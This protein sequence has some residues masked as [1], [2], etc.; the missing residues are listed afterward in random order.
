MP[1]GLVL[2]L[3]LHAAV[4]LV[5]VVHLPS[6]RDARPPAATTP[7]QV[8][9]IAEVTNLPPPAPKRDAKPEPPKPEAARE[10]PAPQPVPPEPE[11]APAAAAAPPPPEPKAAPPAPPAPPEPTRQAEPAPPPKPEPE[12]PREVA[13]APKPEPKPESKPEPPKKAPEPAKKEPQPATEKAP[14]PK[15]EPK[16]AQQPKE[17]GKPKTDDLAAIEKLV[18]DVR[19]PEKAP[20]KPKDEPK[21]KKPEFSDI[22]KLLKNRPKREPK[23][24]EPPPSTDLSRL[25]AAIDRTAPRRMTDQPLTMSEEDALRRQIERCWSVPAGAKD[26]QN[27]VVEIKVRLNRDGSVIEASPVQSSRMADPFYRIAAESAVRAVLRCQPL[28]VPR[29]KYSV[30]KE[31][32]LTFNPKDL[33][34]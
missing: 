13:A 17:P 28:N 10:A 15:P 9:R 23:E 11:P 30:W 4:L 3:L 18:K 14:Q 34:G 1:S 20:D 12:A 21:P 32:T 16:V 7:V 5:A 19:K 27:L 24:T 2:S 8:V 29:D 26:A 22:E 31:M 33:L 25:A 6:W